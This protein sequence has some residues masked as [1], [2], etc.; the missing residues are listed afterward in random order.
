VAAAAALWLGILSGCARGPAPLLTDVPTATE[1]GYRIGWQTDL[2]LPDPD[3]IESLTPMGQM[4]V[5]VE[6]SKII[7]AVD[8][9]TGDIRWRHQ[10]TD[11]ITEL[12]DPLAY[13]GDVVVCTD[14]RAHVIHADQGKL[15]QRFD[16]AHRA[17]TSPVLHQ[18]MLVFGTPTG[19]LFAQ[20]TRTG[21][22]MWQYKMTSAISADPV[23]EKG[24]VTVADTTGNVAAISAGNGNLVWRKFKPPWDAVETQ[25]RQAGNLILVACSDQ[26]LYAFE[27]G[28]GNLSW[29]YLTQ[30]PLTHSPH[31]IGERVF[32]HTREHGVVCLDLVSGEVQWQSREVTGTPFM[33]RGDEVVFYEP[34]A[35]G[36]LDLHFVRLDAGEIARTVHLDHVDHVLTDHADSGGALYLADNT[37]RIMKLLPR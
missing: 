22:L 26:K 35:D 32:Q 21:T 31:V 36:G 23:I 8:T 3:R 18:G 29:Q 2:E 24:F 11:D 27:R 17:S 6:S 9:A 15:I 28:S 33:R 37:G 4:L 1:L 16:L 25:I 14:V 19:R 12:T 34:D 20:A 5:V 13:R 7:E 30:F 10:V